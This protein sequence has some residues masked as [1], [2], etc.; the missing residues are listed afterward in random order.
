MLPNGVLNKVRSIILE[1]VPDPENMRYDIAIRTGVSPAAMAAAR[2]GTVR[3]DGRGQDPFLVHTVNGTEY[4]IRLSTLRGAYRTAE[5]EVGNGL[6]MWQKGDFKP[7]PDDLLQERLYAIQWMRPSRSGRGEVY[8]V[9][10]VSELDH[11][12]ERI[13]DQY[14]AE[15]FSEWQGNGLVPDMRIEPGAE[16]SRLL[17][18]RG[19]THWHHLFNTRQLLVGALLN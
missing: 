7:R 16:T 14:V 13:A 1:L 12:R 2:I 6:R 9:R 5:G 18:E 17:K 8:E 11:M 15:H 3:S 10:A 4:R 19:W